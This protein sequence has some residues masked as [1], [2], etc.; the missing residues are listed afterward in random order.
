[1]PASARPTASLI[2]DPD[3]DDLYAELTRLRA[4]VALHSPVTVA[5]RTVC[6]A[7]RTEG[8]CPT[9]RTAVPPEVIAPQSPQAEGGDLDAGPGVSGGRP[10][11]LRTGEPLEV[12]A[13][14]SLQGAP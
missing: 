13:P 8:H 5:G 4:A 3:L 1:M 12:I 7:C 2:T 14:Q 10:P 9:A 11:G 6:R